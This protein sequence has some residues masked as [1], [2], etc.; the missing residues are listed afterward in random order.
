MAALHPEDI[1]AKKNRLSE[2]AVR[3]GKAVG[4]ADKKAT[5]ARVVAKEELA[6]ITKQ[7]EALRKQV[8]KTTKRLKKEFS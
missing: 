7:L 3:I 6:A 2:V 4:K 1:M 5:R 8:E